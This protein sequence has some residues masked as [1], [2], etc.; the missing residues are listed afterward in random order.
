MLC[1][2]VQCLDD[3]VSNNIDPM[4]LK[5]QCHVARIELLNC[6]EMIKMFE[7]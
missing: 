1:G 2:H 6:A 3:C 7:T 5:M 4:N